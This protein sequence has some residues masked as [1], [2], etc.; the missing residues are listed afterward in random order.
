M[1]RRS[2]LGLTFGGVAAT[3]AVRTWPF[4]VF[5]FPTKPILRATSVRF[6]RQFDPMQ[7]KMISRFDVL[8][9]FGQLHAPSAIGAVKIINASDSLDQETLDS[10]KMQCARDY[11]QA[12]ECIPAFDRIPP[13]SDGSKQVHYGWDVEG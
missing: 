7:Q 10:F 6:I 8:Y 3:A 11:G 5:S 4:R 1:N 13:P 12:I 9:G 2:F